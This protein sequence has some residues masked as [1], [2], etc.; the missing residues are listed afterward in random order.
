M[1]QVS[2]FMILNDRHKRNFETSR[3]FTD[4]ILR[5]IRDE[6]VKQEQDA[7]RLTIVD[8]GSLIFE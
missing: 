8:F 2:H 3:F 6:E 4:L 1:G 5:A 7:E